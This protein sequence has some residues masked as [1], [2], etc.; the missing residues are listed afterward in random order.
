MRPCSD[1]SIDRPQRALIDTQSARYPQTASGAGGSQFV[2]SLSLL[3]WLTAPVTARNVRASTRSLLKA[4][5]RSALQALAPESHASLSATTWSISISPGSL[6]VSPSY[7]ENQSPAT[8]AHPTRSICGGV[9]ES[10]MSTN[11]RVRHP[12]P[13]IGEP[14]PNSSRLYP[15]PCSRSIGIIANTSIASN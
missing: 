11:A 5:S 2:G 4:S 10:R 13:S 8:T 14:Y 1:S 12:N 6:H 3:A 15:A 9:S 7:V